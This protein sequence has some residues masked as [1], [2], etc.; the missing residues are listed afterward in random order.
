VSKPNVETGLNL[1]RTV[2]YS[3]AVI[4]IAMT[5]LA[6]ELPLPQGDTPAGVWRSFV[7]NLGGEYLA[8]IISFGVIALFW[9]RHHR[10]FQ[11]VA[12]INTVLIVWNLLSLLAV[13]LIPF[14]TK[15]LSPEAVGLHGSQENGYVLGPV[16][17]STIMLTWGAAYVMI[18][19]T[20]SKDGLWREGT[21]ATAPGSMIFGACAA[22]AM[23][24]VSIPIA[25]LAGA[26]IAQLSWLLIPVV[27]RLAP[28][29]RERL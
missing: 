17:Y 12:R 27:A 11:L 24:A 2:Y 28:V 29:V 6:I 3:D 8:F 21:P 16:L 26:D 18:V 7:S 14:A 1:E 19:R 15:M 4:A 10:T 5:L 23:F 20:A 13:V 22:L 9:Y 25:F